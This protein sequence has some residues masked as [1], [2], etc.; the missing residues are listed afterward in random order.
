MTRVQL[1]SSISIDTDNYQ[2]EPLDRTPDEVFSKLVPSERQA[3]IEA[4]R[5]EFKDEILS[6]H[7]GDLRK[8]NEPV[9]ESQQREETLFKQAIDVEITRPIRADPDLPTVPEEANAFAEFIYRLSQNLADCNVR[10]DCDDNE[11]IILY[12]G[13]GYELPYIVSD[14]IEDPQTQ[15]Y[16]IPCASVMANYTPSKTQA[17]GYNPIVVRRPIEAA[18][19]FIAADYFLQYTKDGEDLTRDGECRIHG[20]LNACIPTED[21]RI[22]IKDNMTGPIQ[23]AIT[24]SEFFETLPRTAEENHSL[25]LE[26]LEQLATRIQQIEDGKQEPKE[27]LVVSSVRGKRRLRD[28]YADS[29]DHQERDRSFDYRGIME[30]VLDS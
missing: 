16:S 17:A 22:I 11:E 27:Q 4:L 18:D 19:V 24:P 5:A 1:T 15:E 12:R 13:M 30:T 26:F 29:H 20:E 10:Q 14:A 8:W 25:F 2:S 28:W 3:I 9:I 6:L 23:K 7:L 21:T